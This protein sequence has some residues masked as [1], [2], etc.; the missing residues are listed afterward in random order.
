MRYK[1]LLMQ[2]QKHSFTDKNHR[3]RNNIEFDQCLKIKYIIKRTI[4]IFVKLQLLVKLHFR[5]RLIKHS[6]LR[7]AVF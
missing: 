6:V 2:M 7:G 3:D 5:I 1:E 4:I